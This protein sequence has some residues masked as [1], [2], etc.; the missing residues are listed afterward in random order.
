VNGTKF[1]IGFLPVMADLYNRLA[2]DMRPKLAEFSLQLKSDLQGEAIEFITVPVSCTKSEITKACE[3]LE[4]RHIDLLVLGMVSYAPSGQILPALLSAKL[5]L[6]LWPAQPM[7][8]LFPQ[9]Y[10]FNA[11]LMNHGVHGAQDIAHVLR[12]RGRRYGMLHGHHTQDGFLKELLEWC[13]AGRFLRSLQS[14]NPCF[15]G[16]YFDDMLDLQL[17]NEKFIA[18]LGIVPKEIAIPQF[19]E[20]ARDIS[21]SRV[22]E[23]KSYYLQK[24]GCGESLSYTLLEKAVR[25]E[26]AL[27]ELLG[28]YDSTAVGINFMSLCNNSE[29]S[30]ACH[31]AA[32]SLMADGIG[33][34]G[35]GD[36]TTAMLLRG[37]FSA[38]FSASFSEQFSVGYKDNRIVLRHWGE[39]NPLLARSKPLLKKSSFIDRQK[40]EFVIMDFEFRAGPV[41]LI[42]LTSAADGSGQLISVAGV[43][44]DTHLPAVDGPRAVFR[45]RVKDVRKLLNDYTTLGGSHHWALV[46]GDCTD[47][48][49]KA[50]K[51]TGWTYINLE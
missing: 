15:I 18:D 44:E 14:C 6:V 45:P 21:I 37:I 20:V 43:I 31:L 36:W 47:T 1:R 49:Q 27:R 24:Y 50:V 11:V 25:H 16:G 4:R 9:E 2:P 5:P 22:N 46:E 8:E 7:P 41:T 23:R 3:E 12:R 19:I 29:I 30:D 51:L 48:L 10:D 33:Y 26:L 40:A 35:E 17:E 34:A 42:N 38:G 32:C 28:Q 13:Q 39:G